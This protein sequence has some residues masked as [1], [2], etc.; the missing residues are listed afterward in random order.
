MLGM[1][2]GVFVGLWICAGLHWIFPEAAS[3][4]F[5]DAAVVV[6]CGIVGLALDVRRRDADR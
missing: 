5:I 1:T 6:T 3:T 4:N 2:G